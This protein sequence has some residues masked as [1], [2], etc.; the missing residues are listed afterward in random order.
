MTI[1]RKHLPLADFH[2]QLIREILI[3]YSNK[4]TLK[5]TSRPRSSDN[6]LPMRLK[7][8]HFPSTVPAT[9]NKS[10]PQWRCYVCNKLKNK[11]K[12]TTFMCKECDVGLCPD[13]CFAIY[14]TKTNI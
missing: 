6:V 14:H 1:T 3:K 5:K 2:L 4:T 11:R 8:R 10:K 7:D 13:P 9:S 12:A